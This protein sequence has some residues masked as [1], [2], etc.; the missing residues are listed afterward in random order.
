MGKNTKEG[1]T[2][3]SLGLKKYAPSNEFKEKVIKRRGAKRGV[4]REIEPATPFAALRILLNI[5]QREW[6]EV[7]DISL[8]IVCQVEKGHGVT[9][10]AVAKRMQDE[11]RKRGIAVTLD[12]LYQH[13]IPWKDEEVIEREA[14]E[15]DELASL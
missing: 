3:Y 2:N 15:S 9:N 8:G 14:A 13:V 5:T 12:E 4:L 7:C 10:I 6:C 11:A 1:M